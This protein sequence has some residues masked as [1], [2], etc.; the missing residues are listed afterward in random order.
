MT[1]IKSLFV[2]SV[3]IGTLG[4][5]GLVTTAKNVHAA[6]PAFQAKQSYPSH[7]HLIASSDAELKQ[8]SDFVQNLAQD[9]INFL[10][11]AKLSHEEKQ[12]KFQ[13]MLNARFDM[14]AIGRFA[15]GKYWRQA[16]P[17]E[18]KDYLKLFNKMILAV[19]SQR[20]SEY[21]GQKSLYPAANPLEEETC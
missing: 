17:Q 3:C 12:R 2:A 11:D 14:N 1:T 20:F 21:E 16:T 4:F 9:A 18:Q 8:G 10:G 6:N 5:S 19:Y 13:N 7:I 15:I